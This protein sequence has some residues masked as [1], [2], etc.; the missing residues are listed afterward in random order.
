MNPLSKWC[1]CRGV[2]VGSDERAPEHEV[3]AD[4]EY[5]RRLLKE[6]YDEIL[7]ATTHQD[8][9]VGRLITSSAFLTAASLALAGL[10]SASGLKRT[11][12][13]LGAGQNVALALWVF[14]GYLVC[15]GLA[16][17][18]F[19]Q[20]ISTPLRIPAFVPTAMPSKDSDADHRPVSMFYFYPISGA[21]LQEWRA[22]WRGADSTDLANQYEDD[23]LRETHNLAVRADYKYSRSN[24]GVAFLS[25]AI[26]LF[27]CSAVLILRAFADASPGGPPQPVD[28]LT[29]LALAVTI[30]A[31]LFLTMVSNLRYGEL[32]TDRIVGWFNQGHAPRG[33]YLRSVGGRLYVGLIPATVTLLSLLPPLLSTRWRW[34]VVATLGAALLIQGLAVKRNRREAKG[35]VSRR[36]GYVVEVA[37]NIVLMVGIFVY[38]EVQQEWMLLACMLVPAFGITLARLAGPAAIRAD[39]MRELVGRVR[40]SEGSSQP[41]SV[42]RVS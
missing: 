2:E 19:V 5:R 39:R 6:S 3:Y 14:S 15:I 33:D 22:Q 4:R 18:L 40:A 21:T 32:E 8:D 28:L 31:W 36:I 7:A 17:T 26:L 41:R 11:Y 20:A 29:R 35:K 23:L 27:L 16:T 37:A 9:K 42:E 38:M 12:D 24:E 10:G 1:R 30:S 25:L 34:A 13:V